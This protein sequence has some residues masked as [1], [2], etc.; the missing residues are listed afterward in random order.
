MIKVLFRAKQ[1]E[2]KLEHSKKS[3]EICLQ[4][5]QR[6]A[7]AFLEQRNWFTKGAKGFHF[8]CFAC[9]TKYR[10]K[11]C[12]DHKIFTFLARHNLVRAVGGTPKSNLESNHRPKF[13]APSAPS[14]G[15]STV[16]DPS[17]LI[18]KFVRVH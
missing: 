2:Q 18:K 12:Y 3:K 13:P 15:G 17:N 14:A 11:R 4:P 10:S 6:D 16:L 8:A 7:F 9:C 1:S 5:E